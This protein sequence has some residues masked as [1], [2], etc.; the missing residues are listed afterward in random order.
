M[1]SLEFAPSEEY[2]KLIEI[3][4]SRKAELNLTNLTYSQLL[5]KKVF[6]KYGY[7]L[8]HIEPRYRL[9]SGQSGYL[10]RPDNIAVLTIREHL[11]AHLY[12]AKFEIGKFKYSAQMALIQLWSLK[13]NSGSVLSLPD[14]EISVLLDG[15]EESRKNYFGSDHHIDSSSKAGKVSGAIRKKRFEND[16]EFREYLLSKL[17]LSDDKRTE[18]C[19]AK[20]DRKDKSPPWLINKIKNTD[21]KNY[22]YTPQLWELFDSIYE[23]LFKYNLS[24]KAIAKVLEVDYHRINNIVRIMKGKKEDFPDSFEKYQFYSEFIKDYKP[25]YLNSRA[26][27]EEYL[28]KRSSVGV[29]MHKASG[30]W[31]SQ[32]CADGKRIHLGLFENFNDALKARKDAERRY[33]S[34]M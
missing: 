32:I 29:H 9:K 6:K 2:L 16:P 26:L 13:S 14:D 19:A 10:N 33:S 24:Y 28:E 5:R 4:D 31:T 3:S 17:K 1:D 21:G 27:F 34:D 20:K 23:G 18:V 7:E 25:T 12:L 11:L 15:I 30:K 8:H 22:K